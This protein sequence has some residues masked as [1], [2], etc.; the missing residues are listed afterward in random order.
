MEGAMNELC[1]LAAAIESE[2]G[3]LP[4]FI[5]KLIRNA[6][7][8]FDD[9]RAGQI[10]VTIRAMRRRGEP[11]STVRLGEQHLDLATFIGTELEQ[12]SLPIDQAEYYAKECWEAF[13]VRKA[14]SILAEAHEAIIQAPAHW[15]TITEG[16]HSALATVTS[17]ANSLIE[18]IA[19]RIYSPQVKP[20][21]PTARYSI[22]GTQICTPG[23]LTTISAQ[24]KAGKSAVI[25]AMTASTFARQDADCLGF[26]SQNPNGHAVIKIDTEQSEFDHWEGNQRAIR[27]AQVDAAPSWLRSYCLTGFSADDVRDAIPIILDQSKKSCGGIHSVFLDGSADATNDVND[28]AETSG[29]ITELHKL[30]I[31]FDCPI[32]N[33]IHVNPGSESKT[34][35]HLGSQLERKSETNLR[36]EKDESGV[37]VIWADKNRRAPIP[38]NTAPRFAWDDE[39]G[40]HVMVQSLKTAKDDVERDVLVELAR[41]IFADRPSMRYADLQTTV[42]NRLT[43]SDK[44]AER[45]VTRC[46]QLGIVK[47]TTAGLYVLNA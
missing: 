1:P 42:K 31:E 41:D 26:N 22:A 25:S 3:P 6:P 36:L 24:A 38:K 30:A 23:N 37:T 28:P 43:V 29:L 46:R 8:S 33:V 16:V 5:G 32:L 7:E 19:E 44:T 12:A 9:T 34:R 15:Q 21:E 10:A 2:N 18:R 13:Q 47:K 39:T 17:D 45:K 14:K 11:V 20:N 35:G 40:M 4:P 27:R